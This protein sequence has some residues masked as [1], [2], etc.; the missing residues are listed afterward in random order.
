MWFLESF[1]ASPRLVPQDEGC[2]GLPG[3]D[4]LQVVHQQWVTLP[5]HQRRAK[6]LTPK[7]FPAERRHRMP[8][9]TR[10]LLSKQTPLTC[11]ILDDS[12]P[13]QNHKEGVKCD[14]NKSSTFL[15]RSAYRTPLQGDFTGIYSNASHDTLETTSL[16][17][18]GTP[19]A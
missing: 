18:R 1:R 11:I 4:K 10:T 13:Y 16:C 6:E 2:R 9:R 3:T 15:L 19:H 7:R 17:G 5:E 12:A 8:R 14:W